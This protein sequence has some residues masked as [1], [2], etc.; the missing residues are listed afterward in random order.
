MKYKTSIYQRKN[1]L[2]KNVIG[3]KVLSPD[4]SHH[5]TAVTI[6]MSRE[7]NTSRNDELLDNKLIDYVDSVNK[8]QS[9]SQGLFLFAG[10]ICFS[11]PQSDHAFDYKNKTKQ[12]NTK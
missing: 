12:T 5:F 4:A 11:S 2:S 8:F 3:M 7:Y 10:Q 9:D 1:K 6:S